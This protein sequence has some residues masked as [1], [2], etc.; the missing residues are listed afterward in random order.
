MSYEQALEVAGAKVLAFEQ[1]GSY[2]GDWWAKVEIDGKLAWINGSYG[3]CSGCDAFEAEIGWE[4]DE[5]AGTDW[6]DVDDP[7]HSK[8][9]EFM[10]KLKAFGAEYLT[11]AL[12]Q[13]EAVKQASEDLE[14]DTD[15]EEMVQFIRNNPL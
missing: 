12:T 7:R 6:V 3:S 11:R 2:Q 9:A 1:F 10:E 8:H 14:W 15:A 13:D 5:K 4:C